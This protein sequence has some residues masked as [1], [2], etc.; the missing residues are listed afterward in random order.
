MECH[1]R[2]FRLYELKYSSEKVATGEGMAFLQNRLLPRQS[3]IPV[4]TRH[5]HKRPPRYG[6]VHELSC[7]GFTA[8]TR[9][10]VAAIRPDSARV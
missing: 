9:L 2:N 7:I 4:V 8:T 6:V 3:E 10:E 5:C 1:E